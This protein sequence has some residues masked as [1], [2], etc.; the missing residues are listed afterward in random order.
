MG[1]P[2]LEVDSSQSTDL[3]LL[4][5]WV[6]DSQWQTLQPLLPLAKLVGND[7]FQRLGSRHWT[8]AEA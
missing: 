8:G 5:K 1:W 6:D 2:K 4:K 7:G 3:C